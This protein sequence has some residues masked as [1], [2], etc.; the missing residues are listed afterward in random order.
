MSEY[1]II[2]GIKAEINGEK[3]ILELARKVG[4]NKYKLC[5]VMSKR[6]KEL[7][8]KIPEEIDKSDKKAISLA[9]DEIYEGK[10]IASDDQNNN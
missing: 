3:N 9:A 1:M 10:I 4:N 6:A 7:E 2:D 5:C 8:K